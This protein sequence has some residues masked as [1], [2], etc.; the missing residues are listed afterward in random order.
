MSAEQT[1]EVNALLQAAENFGR[2]AKKK[3]MGSMNS[4]KT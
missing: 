4:P 3:E 2:A 1:A